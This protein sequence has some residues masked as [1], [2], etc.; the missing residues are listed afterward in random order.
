MPE[1]TQWPARV[2]A[3]RLLCGTKTIADGRFAAVAEAKEAM[4]VASDKLRDANR[5]VRRLHLQRDVLRNKIRLAVNTTPGVTP[6]GP[7]DSFAS[8]VMAGLVW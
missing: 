1:P 8:L 6:D 2:S 5:E 4:R 7:P 3:D